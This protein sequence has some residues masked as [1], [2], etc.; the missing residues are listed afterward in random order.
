MLINDNFS[1]L[2]LSA[3]TLMFDAVDNITNHKIFTS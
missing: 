1:A 3:E 2:Y